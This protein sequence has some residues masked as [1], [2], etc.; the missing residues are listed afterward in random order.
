MSRLDPV[1]SEKVDIDGTPV[2]RPFIPVAE[3]KYVAPQLGAGAQ[4]SPATDQQQHQT[5]GLGLGLLSGFSGCWEAPRTPQAGG[6][7][8]SVNQKSDMILHQVDATLKI[9]SEGH[10][11]ITLNT[12]S[13][14]RAS[15]WDAVFQQQINAESAEAATTVDND[16]AS[17]AAFARFKE[18][19]FGPRP[20]VPSIEEFIEVC[21]SLRTYI[22][23]LDLISVDRMGSQSREMNK[24]SS[25]CGRMK[26]AN[27]CPSQ[28]Q[29]PIQSRGGSG[30]QSLLSMAP[31]GDTSSSRL[32]ASMGC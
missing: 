30:R 22:Q 4:H 20:P 10:T 26:M 12:D 8:P 1:V 9:E 17:Q 3:R 24:E 25:S 2:P 23:V 21:S 6:I 7:L 11:H 15:D 29:Q 28:I 16:Q 13:A 18:A 5:S 32:S 27:M 14:L 31:T 19:G